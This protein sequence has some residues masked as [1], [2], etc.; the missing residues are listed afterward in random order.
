MLILLFVILFAA[1][2]FLTF[3]TLLQVNSFAKNLEELL[4]KTNNH[5]YL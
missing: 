3:L 1:V 5:I 4:D 2:V